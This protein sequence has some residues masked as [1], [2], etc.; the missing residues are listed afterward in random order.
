MGHDLGLAD[1]LRAL[2]LTVVEVDGWRTRGSDSFAPRG[3]VNHHT[4]GAAHGNAPSLAT[5]IHG[6][7]DLPGPLCNAMMA[8]DLTI[9][10]VAAGR[11]NHAGLGGWRGLA[12]NSSVYGLEIENV[13]TQ[14]E[15]WRPDQFAAAARVHAAFAQAIQPHARVAPCQHYEWTTRKVDAHD[16]PGETL[17][18]MTAMILTNPNPDPGDDFMP[19]QYEALLAEIA[20][21]SAKVDELAN[22]GGFQYA[23]NIAGEANFIEVNAEGK[24]VQWIQRE[25][26]GPL[27]QT[28]IQDGCVPN[29]PVAV[30]RSV[31]GDR[32]VLAMT[33]FQHL[34]ACFAL[35][36]PNVGHWTVSN[37]AGTGP[38]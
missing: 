17:R 24:L 29:A 3:S 13:G 30:L 11:A 9:Y 34:G 37:H 12:G 22:G 10:V 4:A 18:V 23:A 2:G 26:G 16:W 7:A 33:K 21:L 35:Y 27:E 32:R 6:R 8:R 1:R 15:P 36:D 20:K 38:G 5:C 28:V 19:G 31:D 25:T 14:A